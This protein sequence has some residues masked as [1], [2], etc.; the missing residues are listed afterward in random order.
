MRI[1]A[2]I[3]DATLIQVIL[4]HLGLWETKNHDPPPLDSFH[5]ANELTVDE[6]HT[7]KS[8]PV[9]IGSSKNCIICLSRFLP[10]P[11]FGQGRG[12]FAYDVIFME[13]QKDVVTF[14]GRHAVGGPA[15]GVCI[16]FSISSV[17]DLIISIRHG[18]VF[19]CGM[20]SIANP[21]GKAVTFQCCPFGHF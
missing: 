16:T 3:E 1:I 15:D 18:T 14:F 10:Q 13:F 7:L 17:S 4:K 19:A 2:F 20:V 6:S 11:F 8:H 9:V 5:T 12:A 21:S